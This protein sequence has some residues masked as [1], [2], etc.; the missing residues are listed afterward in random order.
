TGQSAN[1]VHAESTAVSTTINASS[2]TVLIDVSPQTKNLD[3]L[4]GALTANGAGN[5]PLVINDQSNP[6]FV[7]TQHFLTSN[8]FT[9]LAQTIDPISDQQV[10][11]TDSITFAG[12]NNL[13]LNTGALPNLVYVESTTVPTTINAGPGNM[14]VDLSE[15][16]GNQNANLDNIE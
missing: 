8:T 12:L 16:N 10:F 2:G 4:V 7:L 9:R 3:D 15:R 6:N 13:V 1:V 5:T 14:L 11:H